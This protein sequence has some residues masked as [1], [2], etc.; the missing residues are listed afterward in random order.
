MWLIM[1]SCWLK[2]WSGLVLLRLVMLLVWFILISILNR[3]L[4][5][6]VCKVVWCWLMIW[7][8]WILVSWSRRV[9]CCIG[10]LC[11]FV[12]CFRLMIWLSSIG[13]W[14]GLLGWLM[15]VCWR[16]LLVSI[17][18][19]LMWLICVVFMCCWRVVGLRVRLFLKGFEW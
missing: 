11:I 17:L 3:L 14:S 6:C 8:C 15:K 18:V 12:W 9:C 7:C 19:V 16:L 13:C 10:S 2:S 4:L 1:V 5:C